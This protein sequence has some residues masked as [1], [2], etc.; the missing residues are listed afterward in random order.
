MQHPRR[1]Y[2][3]PFQQHVLCLLS[4]RSDDWETN[5]SQTNLGFCV[6]SCL[7]QMSRVHL[8][9]SHNSLCSVNCVGPRLAF[10]AFL[11]EIQDTFAGKLPPR[12]G[13]KWKGNS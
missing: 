3:R 2:V 5:S 6:L 9:I 12:F 13:T 8:D 4:T 1:K 7:C 11:N 10:V